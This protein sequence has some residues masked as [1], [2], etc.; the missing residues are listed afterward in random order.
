MGETM[1]TNKTT[2]HTAN[3]YLRILVLI[4]TALCASAANAQTGPDVQ[5]LLNGSPA[6]V[7]TYAFPFPAGSS[8]LVLDNG[9]VRFT[10]NGKNATSQT[11]L[12]LSIIA[13]GQQ[14]APLDGQNTF[15]VDASGGTPSL[16]CSQVK[17]LRN[18]A[19]LVEVAFVD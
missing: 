1:K 19:D 6:D 14:L 16:V 2:C 13:N 4:L 18:S 9:L 17:V 8:G 11:M 3:Q 5:V 12:A 10:F 15:Y 7:G